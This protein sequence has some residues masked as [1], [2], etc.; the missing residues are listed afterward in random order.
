[1]EEKDAQNRKVTTE[2][3]Y[4]GFK[5]MM[6]YLRGYQKQI[7]VLSVIGTLSAIG[8]GFIPYIAGRFFDSIIAP[9]TI[10]MLGY[11]MPV[12]VV[13]LIVW[14]V[15]Q[16]I[17]YIMDWRVNIISNYISN[18]IWLDYLANGFG[19][20]LNLPASFHKKSKI[21]DVSNQIGQAASALESIIGNI[22][23]DLAPQILSIMIALAIACYVNKILTLFLFLGL[24]VY[25]SILLK[26]VK[27]LAGLQKQYRKH[28]SD[29]YGDAYDTMGNAL[30]IKQATSE[31][32]EQNK[33]SE[34]FKFTLPLWMKQAVIW[35][36]LSLY[37]RLTILATQI[38][39][40]I[41]SVHYIHHGMMTLGTLLAFNAYAAMVFG[42]FITIARQWQTIQNGIINIQE[43]EKILA[44]PAEIY[45]PKDAPSIDIQGDIDFKN[46]S[47][48]YDEG[49]PVLHDISFSIKAGD[50]VALVGESGVGKSTLIDLI[51][52]YHFANSGEVLID[53]HDVRTLNLRKLRQ[54]IA[55]VPQ[56]V[57]LFNDTIET[58]IKYGNFEATHELI[59]EAAR[60]AHALDFIEKFP[61]RW[62]QLV[63]ERGIKLSVGQKQRIAIARAILRNPHILVLDEPTSAL[64]AGTEKIITES[65]DILMK[66]KTTFI[67]AHRLS[68]VRKANTILVFKEG[69]IIESGMHAELLTIERGE[70][71]RLYELQIG[72]HG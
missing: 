33:L 56:E 41:L 26:E 8:N 60:K 34:N 10:N 27:P 7:V 50:I 47:F 49:K 54:A 14:S 52:G 48:R 36:N 32:Y 63:G 61:D 4:T 18:I 68:T 44:L 35:G 9:G 64:D 46:V 22:V 20:L 45:E 67:I 30:A 28:M 51:S 39:I 66:G 59:R 53:G 13:L 37:Q 23:I 3:I 11:S 2:G 1:M 29:T 40:F 70:Y 25:I 16:C 55:V 19:F 72:L 17:T 58:N 57:V 38:L 21:G 31:A 6:R 71:K 5:V 69:R 62:K 43:T 42:P 24:I 12:Y 15:V 65:L